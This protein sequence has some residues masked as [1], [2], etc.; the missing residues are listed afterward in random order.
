MNAH[1]NSNR[2]QHWQLAERKRYLA[3]LESLADRLRAD[4][5]RLSGRI[6]EAGGT[7]AAN[8]ARSAF[9]RPLVER[10][11]KL[12]RSIAEIDTQIAEA[13]EAVA[14]AQ[15]EIKLLEGPLAQRGFNAYELRAARRAPRA[16]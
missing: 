2:L 12:Q 9:I 3:E 14:V 7:A 11:D 10:R 5:E 13:R 15:R 8:L 16:R 4:A 1:K 6:S